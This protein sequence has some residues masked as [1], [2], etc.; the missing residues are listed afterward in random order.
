VVAFAYAGQN[1]GGS[2]GGTDPNMS[3]T[4]YDTLGNTYY[5]GPMIN[6]AK[7]N[8]SAIQIFFAPNILG[9]ANTVTAVSD[10]PQ[11]ASG[12]TG[13][14][15]M[16]IKGLATTNVVDV[17][18]G[19]AAPSST[20]TATPGSVKTTSNCDFIAGGM[21]DGH[22]EAS[23]VT[24]NSGYVESIL[25][26]YDPAAFVYASPI[27]TKR[28]V[29]VNAS[30]NLGTADDGW[31]AAQLAFRAA[32]TSANP[33]PTQLAFTTAAQT[34]NSAWG[35]SGVVTVQSQNSAGTATVTS[36][37]ITLNLSGSGLRYF[38]DSS[39]AYPLNST[40]LGAGMSSQ[41]FYFT[42]AVGTRTLSVAATGF[43]TITQSETINTANN[44]TWI[45]GAGCT[46]WSTTTCWQGSAVPGTGAT[47]FFDSTCTSNCSPTLGAATSIGGIWMGP[48]YT[49]TISGS[50]FAF[51][52]T[53]NF[54]INAG[55][56]NAGTATHSIKGNWTN[57]GGTFTPSTGKISFSDANHTIT[58][59]N[60]FYK[61]SMAVSRTNRTLTIVHGTTQT[62]TNTLS[63]NGASGAVLSLRSDSTGTAWNLVPP[64]STTLTGYLNVEDSNS[65]A[66]IHSGANSTNA[67]NNTNWSFP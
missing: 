57:N 48:T 5:A 16:E 13:L 7:Y 33:Q 36:T 10:G 4:V 26:Q 55:V 27:G 18:S 41:S 37:G 21:Q 3:F 25:D 50:T 64:S 6:N 31:A 58:G 65:S 17:G 62:I 30:I 35:C 29:A 56:F 15:L 11:L 43:T 59:S 54:E 24:A 28:N 39:C 19:Q 12:E 42:G 51:T 49:G 53:N 63:L 38:A 1:P 22:V 8:D 52:M 9:G 44:N 66:T 32:V 14:V 20:A 34:F 61:L 60:T 45:G 23:G 46:T 47:A 2:N 67:G 40:Y